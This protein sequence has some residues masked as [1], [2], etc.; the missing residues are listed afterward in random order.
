M[1]TCFI[2]D[3]NLVIDHRQTVVAGFVVLSYIAPLMIILYSIKLMFMSF[4]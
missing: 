4:I 2:G 3:L 1:Y